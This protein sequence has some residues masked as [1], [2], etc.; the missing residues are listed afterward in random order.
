[1]SS[2]PSRV[3]EP[4]KA[5]D[6]R[7]D[8]GQAVTPRGIVNARILQESSRSAAAAAWEAGAEDEIEDTMSISQ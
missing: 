2:L 5:E 7:L 6:P 4:L 8:D 1:M 3:S